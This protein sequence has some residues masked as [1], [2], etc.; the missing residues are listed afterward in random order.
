MSK[1]GPTQ[2]ATSPM[3]YDPNPEGSVQA[4]KL[5]QFVAASV[6]ELILRLMK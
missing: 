5:M 4:K 6:G 1:D 3:L 2:N